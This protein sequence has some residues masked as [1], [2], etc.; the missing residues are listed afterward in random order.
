MVY[1][2][3]CYS[4]TDTLSQ[5]CYISQATLELMNGPSKHQNVNRRAIKFRLYS[6]HARIRVFFAKK[7]PVT[8]KLAI[9]VKRGK[10]NI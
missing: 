1:G 7:F 8:N 6:L 3:I 2:K 5:K 9:E 4:I 10:E